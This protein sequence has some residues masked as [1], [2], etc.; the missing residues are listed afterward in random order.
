MIPNTTQDLAH[1]FGTRSSTQICLT[2]KKFSTLV[3]VSRSIHWSIHRS[4]H[5]AKYTNESSQMFS[6]VAMFASCLSKSCSNEANVGSIVLPFSRAFSTSSHQASCS[7]LWNEVSP[8]RSKVHCYELMLL[9]T[10]F[11]NL[12]VFRHFETVTN[13]RTWIKSHIYWRML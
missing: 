1:I 10:I 11:V 5:S 4:S 9:I 3:S 8:E 7:N 12:G 2:L 13:I 6:A